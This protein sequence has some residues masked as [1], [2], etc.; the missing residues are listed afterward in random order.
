MFDTVNRDNTNAI[1]W[2]R[3]RDKG[4][5][6]MWVADMDLASPQAITDALVK[7]ASHPVYGYTHPWKSLNQSV[8]DWCQRQYQWAIEAD[9]IVWMPGVVPSFNLAVDLFGKQGKVVVQSPNYPPMLAAAERQGC[10]TKTT[11]VI[12][13]DDKWQLDWAHLETL[14]ADPDCHL[15]LLCNPMNPHGATLTKEDLTRL[16]ELANQHDV[17]VCSD[18]IHCDLILDGS[19]HIPA[20]SVNGLQG[21][22]VTLMAASK[23]FNVAGLGCSFAIIPHA[24]VRQQWQARMTDLIPYPNLMGL[25]AAE[26]A[27]SQ[28]DDWHQTLLIQ[29]KSNQ[30]LLADRLNKL[31]GLNYRPQSATFLAWIESTEPGVSLDK[32]F[33]HAGVMPSEGVYFGNKDH[34]RLNFGTGQ[35]T[36]ERGIQLLE[37]YWRQNTR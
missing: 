15:F 13:K 5:L 14:M 26:T 33:I 6:P 9:W 37:N 19:R 21:N 12:W 34:V 28:C 16:A 18:E 3:Y 4:L 20:S 35:E 25:V 7:R 22:S 2:E 24:K 1:K 11:D 27:F 36:L 23:T 31:E 32:P 17:F 8:V 10:K 29:L 30:K